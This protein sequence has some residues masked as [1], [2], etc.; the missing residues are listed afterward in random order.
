MAGEIGNG[1]KAQEHARRPQ[2]RGGCRGLVDASDG[3]AADR[4]RQ[5]E[6]RWTEMQCKRRWLATLTPNLKLIEPYP[7][8]L[9]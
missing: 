3:G 6:V 5:K 9:I 4:V 1:R 8:Q 2:R 7:T